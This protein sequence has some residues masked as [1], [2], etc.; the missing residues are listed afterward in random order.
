MDSLLATQPESYKQIIYRSLRLYCAS[1]FKVILL[2]LLLSCVVFIPRILSYA[3]EQDI[4]TNTSL[5]HI[6]RLWLLLVDLAALTIFIGMLWRIHCVII[7]RHERFV[8][9]FLMGLKKVIYAALAAFIQNILIL[10]VGFIIIAIQVLLHHYHLLFIDTL[11]GTLFT[12]LVFFLQVAF[13]LYFATLFIFFLPLIAIENKGIFSAIKR[14]T[15]L[16][17]NHWWRVFSTQITPWIYYLILLFIIK[18]VFHT[19][20]H[21]YFLEQGKHTLWASLI[22]LI[23][24]ALFTPWVASIMLVQLNDLELR[25]KR[26][27]SLEAQ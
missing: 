2:S 10:A 12:V 8:E 5:F 3:T 20:I 19:N 13:L 25:H 21:I 22:H 9:D 6:N 14:S 11:F 27:N 23:L 17:W 16:V 7:A 1:F 26:N 24:F 4:L 18:Y 15:S